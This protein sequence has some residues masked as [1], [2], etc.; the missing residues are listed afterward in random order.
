MK[1]TIMYF[2]K[3]RNKENVFREGIIIGVFFIISGV[4][5]L[6]LNIFFYSVLLIAFAIVF[7]SLSLIVLFMTFFIPATDFKATEYFLFFSNELLYSFIGIPIATICILILPVTIYLLF[8]SGGTREIIIFVLSFNFTLQLSSL[9]YTS[10]K[11]WL[12]NKSSGN[13]V[14]VKIDKGPIEQLLHRFP[15][16][17]D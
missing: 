8:F 3:R 6:T 9:I 1:I 10:V 16:L 5:L 13:P 2:A 17:D 11:I 12:N 4:F 7:F 15:N 14:P